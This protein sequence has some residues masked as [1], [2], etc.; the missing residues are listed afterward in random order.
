MDVE[1]IDHIEFYVADADRAADELCRGYG[2]AVHARGDQ[3]TGLV[4]CRSVLVRQHDISILLTSASTSD[5]PAAGYV[6]R[7]G[8]GPAVI[9][10]AVPDARAC[11][12]EAVRS[13]A[14]PLAPPAG[15]DVTFASVGGFGDV[16]HRFVTRRDPRAGFAPGLVAS[17]PPAGGG[18]LLREIDHIAVCLAAGEL[19]PTVRRYRDVFGF[20][21]TFEEHIMVGTQAMNSIVVQSE[22][23]AATFTFLEPDTTRNRGQIDEFLDSHGG[24]GVQHV[25]LRT[26]AI[27]DAVRDCSGRGVRFLDTPSSYYDLLPGRLG[28]GLPVGQLRELSILADRDAWGLMFQIFSKS[29]HPRRTFFYELIER[30]GALT[31]GSRNIKALYEAVERQH[32]LSE[33]WRR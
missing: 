25:A 21:Q 29:I 14:T 10:F 19:V 15:D 31:F 12:A 3:H 33:E 32:A 11:F 4:G 13:G 16:A 27:T 17:P 26:P 20:A 23:R 30:R 28:P 8:D 2:F 1:K 18:G 9:A 24:A 6:R 7:H 5:H 22:S